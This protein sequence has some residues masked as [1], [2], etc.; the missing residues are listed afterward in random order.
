MWEEIEEGV[1]VRFQKMGKGKEGGERRRE[2][3]DG[4][5]VRPMTQTKENKRKENWNQVGTSERKRIPRRRK[6]GKEKGEEKLK[7]DKKAKG[8]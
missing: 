3:E 1:G 5:K 4:E 7:R 8:K 6:K 2:K